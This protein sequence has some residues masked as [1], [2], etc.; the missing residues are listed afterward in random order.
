MRTARLKFPEDRPVG[1][2]HCLTRVVDRRFVF[3]DAEKE[4]FVG[5]RRE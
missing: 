3:D 1:F 4:H 5:L 2:Y